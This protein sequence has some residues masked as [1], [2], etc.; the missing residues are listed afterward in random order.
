MVDYDGIFKQSLYVKVRLLSLLVL[1]SQTLVRMRALCVCVSVFLYHFEAHV[2]SAF[3][4]SC[5]F[6][7]FL[8]FLSEEV[9]K[10]KFTSQRSQ[11]WLNSMSYSEDSA[12]LLRCSLISIPCSLT[13]Q[14]MG[15]KNRKGFL[16]L[17][18]NCFACACK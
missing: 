17:A 6:F 11:D 16:I 9:C 5:Q 4:I 2:F 7:C 3:K 13:H 14:Y 18:K 12:I 8:F 1:R 10:P 15:F